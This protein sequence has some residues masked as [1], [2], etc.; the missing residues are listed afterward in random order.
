MVTHEE[1][2]TFSACIVSRWVLMDNVLFFM[3]KKMQYSSNKVEK[4]PAKW[5]K[6]FVL[7]HGKFFGGV[8]SKGFTAL[9]N[10][11][12]R[13]TVSSVDDSPALIIFPY[14]ISSLELT[15]TVF[16]GFL[17]SVNQS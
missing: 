11:I 1:L 12:T 5:R 15:V 16:F 14:F 8:L 2:K 6:E 4:K 13:Q 3:A 17:L 10:K 9:S 7:K